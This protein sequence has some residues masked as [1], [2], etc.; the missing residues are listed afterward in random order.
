MLVP[1]G[2][3]GGS[4]V[5]FALLT[6]FFLLPNT[7]LPSCLNA[8]SLLWLLYCFRHRFL[9][10]ARFGPPS[11]WCLL[12]L[13]NLIS[14]GRFCRSLSFLIPFVLLP[15]LNLAVPFILSP[16]G[17]SSARRFLRPAALCAH[18]R[19]P[20]S[21]LIRFVM[22]FFPLRPRMPFVLTPCETL[23]VALP[24]PCF[25]PPLSLWARGYAAVLFC[26]PRAPFSP[27]HFF[28]ISSRC[29]LSSFHPLLT[30]KCCFRTCFVFFSA[31]LV[32]S[33]VLVFFPLVPLTGR[34]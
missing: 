6:R 4:A 26:L 8:P 23:L 10:L 5:F 17:T 13:R 27:A 12:A 3:A 32:F 33:L 16:F 11:R 22:L 7:A 18:P 25:W 30:L 28:P 9:L 19:P 34:A 20:P 15:R 2:P 14:I 29:Y 1:L 24:L 31:L 21:R